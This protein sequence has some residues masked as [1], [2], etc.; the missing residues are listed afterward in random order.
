MHITCI[1]VGEDNLLIQCAKY[2]LENHHKIDC[3]ASPVQ[4]IQAWCENNNISWVAS[5]DALSTKPEKSVDYLFSI[6][7]SRI[8]KES[9]LKIARFGAINYHDSLL[10]K[11]AGVNATT[12]TIING[13]ATHGITWHRVDE[14]IDTGDIVYQSSFLVSKKDTALTLNL[15]CFD[16]ATNGFAQMIQMIQ[17]SSLPRIMQEPASRS[18][19]GVGHPLPYLGFIHWKVTD[20]QNIDALCRAL[21]FGNYKNNVGT[22]KLQLKDCYLIIADVEILAKSCEISQS[23]VVLS[24]EK[25]GITVSTTNQPI[26]IKRLLTSDC[27]EVSMDDIAQKYGCHVNDRFPLLSDSLM[28]NGQILYSKAIR[29]EKFWLNNLVNLIDHSV[30]SDRIFGNELKELDAISLDLPKKQINNPLSTLLTSVLIYLYRLN[31]YENSSV[32]L[33]NSQIPPESRTLWS[34]LLPMT[35]DF[36]SDSTCHQIVEAVE[37]M[38]DT[39]SKHGTFLTDIYFRQPD[40]KN[41]AKECLISVGI[42]NDEMSA[43]KNS[44]IHFQID[45]KNH[46]IKIAH[47]LNSNFQGGTIIPL[48][49]N[50]PA[51]ITNILQ[52]MLDNPHQLIKELTFLTH[53]EQKELFTWGVGEYLPLPSNTI[54]DLFEQ[55]VRSTPNHL[56]IFQDAESLTY[57]RLWEEAEKITH[58]VNELNLAPQTLIGI[59]VHPGANLVA[60]ILGIIKAGC[61]AVPIISTN[62]IL[63]PIIFT[64]GTYFDSLK[65]QFNNDNS[66]QIYRIEKILTQTLPSNNSINRSLPDQTAIILH[67]EN[68]HEILNH[69]NIINYTYWFARTTDFKSNCVLEL[70]CELPLDSLILCLLAPLFAGGALTIGTTDYSKISHLRLTPTIFESLMKHPDKIAQ[71][72]PTHVL[73]TD[74][75]ESEDLMSKWLSHCPESRFIVIPSPKFH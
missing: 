15:R 48:I 4:S 62:K 13:E 5:L 58:F 22:L 34:D 28:E 45:Q 66:P 49:E 43:P 10:P 60:L 50:M 17:T 27:S 19:F 42:S 25:K 12:W 52:S 14:G 75:I 2:L 61:I 37:M 74:E 18:Y 51:H 64:S 56:V 6:V 1:L 23:G 53:E 32:F 40:L 71:L 44:L 46:E 29:N 47:R 24:I 55:R 36:K 73:L 9:T 57:H 65:N 7:N 68:N 69:K 3:V 26:L 39:T 70:S 31:N 20:A 35:P 59:H 54:T 33:V 21:N 38:L 30:Y 16:E 72:K 11:Y 63:L 67:A 8:L 41:A